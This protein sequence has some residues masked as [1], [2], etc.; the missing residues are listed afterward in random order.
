M[1]G[2]K[3]QFHACGPGKTWHLIAQDLQKEDLNN[4]NTNKIE[5]NKSNVQNDS[6][7]L[8]IYLSEEDWRNEA[9]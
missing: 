4:L 9:L 3:K 7:K 8:F 5:L 1:P 6:K 2:I